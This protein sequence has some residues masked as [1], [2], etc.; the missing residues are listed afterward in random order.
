MSGRKTSSETALGWNSRASAKAS[1]PA[2]SDE[3][4]EALIVREIAENARVMR[5][6]L[7]DEQ[8]RI[9]NAKIGTIVRN[10]FRHV[11]GGAGGREMH[12]RRRQSD[13]AIVWHRDTR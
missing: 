7:N 4:F 12:R 2:R 8:D 5:I 11:D 1:A 9:I 6:V 13:T 3:D 10:L